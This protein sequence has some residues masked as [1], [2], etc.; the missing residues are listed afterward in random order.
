MSIS[1]I[2]ARAERVAKYVHL[3]KVGGGRYKAQVNREECVCE[4]CSVDG[5]GT[6]AEEALTRAVDLLESRPVHE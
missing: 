1:K 6:T 5:R 3:H 2:W 4:R